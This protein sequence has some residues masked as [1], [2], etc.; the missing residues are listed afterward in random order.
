MVETVQVGSEVPDFQ[1]E[2]YNPKTGDFDEV[3][4]GKAEPDEGAAA[5][6]IADLILTD[7]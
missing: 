4:R 3:N 7:A 2:T 1:L 6:A 5:A